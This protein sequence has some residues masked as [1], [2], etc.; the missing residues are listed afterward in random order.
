[1]IRMIAFGKDEWKGRGFA[2]KALFVIGY[3]LFGRDKGF[4]SQSTQRVLQGKV[5]IVIR[6]KPL[7]L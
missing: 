2:G 6:E 1:M 7:F 3:L 5:L 4:L